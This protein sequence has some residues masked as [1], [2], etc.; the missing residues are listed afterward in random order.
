MLRLKSDF[1]TLKSSEGLA[2]LHHRRLPGGER[3]GKRK[4]WMIFLERMRE[5]HSIRQTLELL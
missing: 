2:A 3:C 1:A 5:G 4:C